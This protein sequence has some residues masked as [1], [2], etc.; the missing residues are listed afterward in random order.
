M[1]VELAGAIVWALF[2][3]LGF[4]LVFGIAFVLFG[5]QR[6][7]PAAE[8]GSWGFRIL[9]LPGVAALWPVLLL[10]WARGVHAPPAE[11]NAHRS[12][13]RERSSQP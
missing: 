12:P 7:D 11:R 13:A 8:H 9:I 5:V 3:W 4:G 2:G 10:R 6:I 1:S